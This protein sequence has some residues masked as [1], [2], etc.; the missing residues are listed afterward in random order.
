MLNIGTKKG[1][2]NMEIS[3]LVKSGTSGYFDYDGCN[4]LIKKIIETDNFPIPR[5]GEILKL[6][7]DNDK[8]L[9]NIKGEIV[10]EYHSY[11]VK[12]IEYFITD[13]NQYIIN[14]YVVSIGRSIPY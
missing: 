5:I 3:I 1:V 9:K 13:N 2:I 11:L 12:D 7:E 10:K 14:I 4:L 8:G 6:L